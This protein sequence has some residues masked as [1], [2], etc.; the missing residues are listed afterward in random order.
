MAVCCVC[1]C[2]Y[3]HGDLTLT[4]TL[5]EKLI[6]VIHIHSGGNKVHSGNGASETSAST[7]NGTVW[8]CIACVCLCLCLNL[9]FCV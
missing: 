9:Y 5:L 4:F 2:I 3:T 7:S 6:H 1:D 8:L